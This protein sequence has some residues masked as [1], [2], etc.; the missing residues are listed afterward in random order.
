MDMRLPILELVRLAVAKEYSQTKTLDEVAMEE[1]RAAVEAIALELL[2]EG[3]AI[4]PELLMLADG[5]VP[6]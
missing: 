2:L 3:E 4:A 5:Q 1:I 6:E